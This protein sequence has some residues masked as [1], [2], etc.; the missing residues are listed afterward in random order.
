MKRFRL[1]IAC[2]SGALVLGSGLAQ[3]RQAPPDPLKEINDSLLVPG[4]KDAAEVL[5]PP[6]AAM[7]APPGAPVGL[8]EVSLMK[9]GDAPWGSWESWASS[10]PQQAALAALKKVTDP[11]EKYTFGL[12][13]GRANVPP[14]WAAAGLLVDAGEPALLALAP[15]NLRY[16]EKLDHLVLLCS[17]EGERLAQADKPDECAALLVNWLRLGRMIADRP[18]AK[19]KA[20]GLQQMI[21][22]AERLADIACLHPALFKEQ[23]VQNTNKDLDPRAV[24]LERV[25]FPIG[26]RLA[27]RQLIA[28]AIDERGSAK[29]DAFGPTMARLTADPKNAYDLFPQAAWWG[30]IGKKHA[31]WFDARDTADKVL[32]DWQKRWELNNIFDLIM[33]TPTDY[34]KMD[35]LKFAMIDQVVSE[36]PTLFTLRTR[37]ST[38]LGGVRSALAVV[39]YR[40]VQGQWPPSLPPVQPRFIQKLDNDP[41]FWQEEREVRDIFRYFVPI[42][43]QPLGPREVAKPHTI[44]VDMSV[45]GGAGESSAAV[46][47][48]MGII[49]LRL[50]A[51]R[52][53]ASGAY[54]SA[55]NTVNVETLKEKWSQAAKSE[56]RRI[57]SDQNELKSMEEALKLTSEFTPE[58][59]VAAARALLDQPEAQSAIKNQAQRV[60]LTA[61]ELKSFLMSAEQAIVNSQSYKTLTDG[62]RGG[63]PTSLETLEAVG[64]EI[65][66][67]GMTPDVVET[68][69][70]KMVIA[71]AN[72]SSVMSGPSISVNLTEADFVI[73][74]VGPDMKADF[75]K[76]VSPTGPD[77]LIW[78]SVLTLERRAKETK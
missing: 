44:R 53:A 19:E 28:L 41:W 65:V 24:L 3:A 32:N 59:L 1:L 49:E 12:K 46:A 66:N 38:Q 9:S 30:E 51:L 57:F 36:V 29:A 48:I 26:E 33:R 6:L 2:V 60:G 15:Q 77:I 63:T 20:W 18:F 5:C 23:T 17:V 71:I 35:R 72:P 27:L 34:S 68:Y 31:G 7:A 54:D 58:Q 8:R 56:A 4:T 37:V 14:E 69:I 55:S 52:E 43:D 74:S 25:R 42:R 73:Y 39:G 75:A 62:L 13:I 22:A 10:E 11:K 47:S 64:D 16:M 45:G 78:P 70:K 76:L 40:S 21:W 50:K 61:E 67:F